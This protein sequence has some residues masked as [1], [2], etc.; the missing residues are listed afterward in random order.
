[1]EHWA[2]PEINHCPTPGEFAEC[3]QLYRAAAAKI[4]ELQTQ[5]DTKNERFTINS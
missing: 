1:M 5:H 2:N 4:Q 3:A